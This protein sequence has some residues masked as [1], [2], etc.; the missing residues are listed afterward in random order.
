[1]PAPIGI[2]YRSNSIRS[3][4]RRCLIK[5]RT[6]INNRRSIEAPPFYSRMDAD[7]AA[8]GVFAFAES[9]VSKAYVPLQTH[10]V[11][12]LSYGFL[13]RDLYTSALR[14]GGITRGLAYWD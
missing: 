6:T 12:Q 4:N 1:M 11:E 9:E 14:E 13:E 8:S 7:P 3:R 5:R 10:G 2:S